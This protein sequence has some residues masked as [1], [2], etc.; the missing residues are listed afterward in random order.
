MGVLYATVERVKL[1]GDLRGADL[2]P[3]IARALESASRSIDGSRPGGGRL[4]RR[5]YPEVATRYFEAL[6]THDGATLPL[7]RHELAAAPTS[8]TNAGTSLI[9]GTDVYLYPQYGPPYDE[10]RLVSGAWSTALR[11]IVV[12]GPWGYGADE[13]PAGTVIEALDASETAVDVSDVSAIGIGSIIRVDSER[14]IVTDKSLL[15]TGQTATC[16]AFND[17]QAITVSDGTQFHAGETIQLDAE[18]MLVRSIAG[19]VLAVTRAYDGSTLDGHT[20]ATIYAPRTL[21]VQRGA[22]G[23]TAATHLINAPAFRHVVP[24]LVESLCIAVA[25]DQIQQESGDYAGTAGSGGSVPAGAALPALWADA[26]RAFKP[27][28]TWLGV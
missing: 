16:T 21:T 20:G 27:P 1:D 18:T 2:N 10:L 26:E 24:A 3:Q 4:G 14:M 17:D 23:T 22:L 19:N 5:F 13:A 6:P 8:I 25:L 15:S 7:G 11:G 28:T 12:T 9:V